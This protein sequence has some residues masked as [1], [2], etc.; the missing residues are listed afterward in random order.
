MSLGSLAEAYWELAMQASPISATSLG[1]RRFDHLMPD[2][3]PAAQRV[4]AG[5]LT[6]LRGQVA[7]LAPAGLSP[8]DQVTRSELLGELDRELRGLAAD[9]DAWNVSPLRG[10]QVSLMQVPA[11]QPLRDAV[12]MQGYLARVTAMPAWLE[13]RTEALRRALAEGRVASI[14]PLRR[15]VA[16]L[17]GILATPAA[18][19]PLA[20]HLEAVPPEIPEELRVEAAGELERV[21]EEELR[22]ALGGY[23]AC[24]RDQVLP[25]ARDAEHPG[26]MHVPGGEEAY[27]DLIRSHTSLSMS[28]AQ[29][30]QV[31]R[32]E[33][34][35]IHQEIRALG[36]ELFGTE[37][38]GA[39]QER[40]R[41]DPALYYRDGAG[42]VAAAEAAIARAEARL[43][44]A[45]GLRPAEA[46][47]VQ[48]IPAR[49]APDSTIGYY[50]GPSPDGSRPG[51]YYVN[52]Y[53]P[54]T[55]ARF[56]T[57]VLAF[58]E[59]VPGHH[60]QIS[61]AQRLTGLPD[62]RRHGGVTAYVEGWALYAEQLAGE[63][64]LYSGP[65]DR[66]GALFFDVKRACRLV[67]DTGLHALGW[68]RAQAI[69]FMVGHS[70]MSGGA[71]EVE[72]DRYT[73]MPGQALAYKLGQL[74][75]LEL[76]REARAA[77][78]AEFRLADFHDRVLELG[79]VGL[80]M[81]SERVRAWHQTVT[82]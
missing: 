13:E 18:A 50:R 42:I 63:L 14:W 76:R 72:V 62:F 65:L 52:T 36:G 69:D 53:A 3:S 79:A 9:L 22:P 8:E 39:I 35:R 74:R 23:L 12:E 73:V 38:F 41:G 61:V 20:T 25:E 57:E 2:E 68:S 10:P 64:E 29:V 56:E 30:H 80:E 21:L 16:Q 44:D 26:I 55:R 19:W 77:R 78:G 27:A 17:E 58:H 59:A 45:F 49:E 54:E 46:C 1:D 37:D 33:V 24:L 11:L 82:V 34:S 31:G 48:P 40:L 47:R 75:L 7:A 32:D 5:R 66:L 43:P 70:L 67:A 71:V 6:E 51:T 28:A 4:L 60:L 81:L 15:S